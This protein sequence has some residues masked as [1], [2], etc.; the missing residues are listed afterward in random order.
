MVVS[1]ALV[2]ALSFVPLAH[3]QVAVGAIPPD[4]LGETLRGEKVLASQH[5]GKVLVVTFWA[6]WCAPC[7]RELP[8]L[9][10]VQRV[11]GS[12][13]LKVV[14]INVEKRAEFRKAA[15]ALADLQLTV[16]HDVT[17]S[18][19][20]AYG[21]SAIPKMVIIGRDGRVL[22]MFR[23]YSEEQVDAVIAEVNAALAGK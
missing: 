20:A 4:A 10:G 22:K 18:I 3:A 6:A 13:Q 14:A 19:S 11:A 17:G 16:T 15:N 2:A 12:A 23:G 21:A 1:A 5:Q 9:E 7:R 8:L